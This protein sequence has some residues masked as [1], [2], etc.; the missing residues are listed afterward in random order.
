MDPW[1]QQTQLEGGGVTSGYV[2]GM[3]GVCVH[4]CPKD[5]V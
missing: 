1:I 4:H 3:Q 5:N 2:I